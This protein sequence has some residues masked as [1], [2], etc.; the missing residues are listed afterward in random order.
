MPKK[1]TP[2][3][4]HAIGH[5]GGNEAETHTK[6]VSASMLHA[7]STEKKRFKTPKFLHKLQNR[8]HASLLQHLLIH[9]FRRSNRK[10]YTRGGRICA[11]VRPPHKLQNKLHFRRSERFAVCTTNCKLQN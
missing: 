9:H 5:F 4:G 8:Y 11:W 2:E 1:I 10:T 6:S 3:T 7:H